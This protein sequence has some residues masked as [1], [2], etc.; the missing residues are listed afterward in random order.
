MQNYVIS[1]NNAIPNIKLLI[2]C[3]QNH[4]KKERNYHFSLLPKLV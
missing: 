3:K 1:K 2:I 4:K